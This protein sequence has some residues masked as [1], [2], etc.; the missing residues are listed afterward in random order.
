MPTTHQLHFTCERMAQELSACDI[1]RTRVVEYK[2]HICC[3]SRACHGLNA[4]HTTTEWLRGI[5]AGKTRQTEKKNYSWSRSKDLR[6]HHGR[7]TVPPVAVCTVLP[8]RSGP[9]RWST[10]IGG[11]IKTRGELSLII[12]FSGSSDFGNPKNAHPASVTAAGQTACHM[13]QVGTVNQSIR[14]L[15]DAAQPL[16][17]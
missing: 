8:R 12:S 1:A 3:R 16:E 15:N 11:L 6:L 14:Q 4:I 17:V 2:Q 10:G 5:G 9:S 13:A 7:R